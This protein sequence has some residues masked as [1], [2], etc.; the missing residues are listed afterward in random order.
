[1]GWTFPFISYTNKRS[2]TFWYTACALQDT[3][4]YDTKCYWTRTIAG[5]LMCCQ[6]SDVD[7]PN[8]ARFWF[9]PFLHII[10]EKSAKERRS[11]PSRRDDSSLRHRVPQALHITRALIVAYP[12]I[13]LRGLPRKTR[14]ITPC[15]DGLKKHTHSQGCAP[16]GGGG[17]VGGDVNLKQQPMYV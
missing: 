13:S 16:R 15:L 4:L 12:N 8:N 10:S 17:G 1:M 7:S 6:L 3:Q 14:Y 5:C 11:I 9:V 2:L